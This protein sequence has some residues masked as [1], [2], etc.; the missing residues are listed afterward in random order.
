[1]KNRIVSMSLAVMLALSVGLIGCGGEGVPEVTEYTLTISSAEGGSVTG[2]GEG[3]FAYDE[4]EK[5]N[6][7]AKP[8]E[9]C[10]FVNWT[11]DI[12]EIADAED[13]T[14]TIAM[15]ADYVITAN[16]EQVN[17]EE[18]F[19]GGDGT[20]GDPYRLVNWC[21]LNN[22]RYFLSAHYMLMN[23]LDSATAGYEELASATANGGK[24]WETI[25]SVFVDPLFSLDIIDPVD[26]FTGSLDGQGHD[27]GD[28]FI[29]RAGEDGV[30]LFGCVVEAVIKNIGVVNAEVT[31]HICVGALLGAVFWGSTVNNS[32]SSGNVTG[33]AFVGGLI[34]QNSAT[35]SNS[36]FSGNVTGENQYVGGLVG[37][38]GG[39]VNSSYSTGTVTGESVVGGLSGGNWLSVSNC[40]S[41]GDVIGEA[42]VGGLVGLNH[43]GTVSHSYS[44]GTVT[45]EWN[46]G[47]LVGE[48]HDGTVS[49][50]H[51][52]YG[53]VLING[54]NMITVGA[55]SEEDFDKWV[56]NDR[57]LDINERLSQQDGYYLINSASDLKQLLAFGQ[58]GLLKFRLTNDLNLDDEPDFY[59]PYLAG[60]FDGD[61]HKIS[62]LN[63][64]LDLLSQVGLFGYLAS[65]GVVTGLGV[66]NVNITGNGYVGSLVG[67]NDGS[68][69]D[70]YSI[71]KVA[72]CCSVGGLVGWVGWR[73]GTV[74]NSYYNYDETLINNDRG[75]ITIGALFNEDFNQWLANGRFLDVNQRLTQEDGCYVISDVSDFKQL[76]AFG[77]NAS[78]RFRLK[79]DLNLDNELN[80]YVPYLAGEF[81]G[82]GH[83]ISNLKLDYDFVAQAGLFGYVA[84]GGKIS[85]VGV[86]NVDVAG[87]Q[88][89]G[90][91]VG[92]NA[93]T[94]NNSYSTGSVTGDGYVGGLVGWNYGAVSN[95][96]STC[97]ATGNGAAGGL[98][99]CNYDVMEP[100]MIINSYSKGSVTGN[101][102]AG[103]LV[104][105]GGSTASNSFWDTQTSGQS[106]SAGGTGK[107]TAEMKDTTTLSGAGWNVVAVAAPNI[108][109]PSYI[110]N[111]V[112]GQTYPFLSWQPIS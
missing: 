17:A 3:T 49:N 6:L 76:L 15:N 41:T 2:P 80:F 85:E 83:E 69:R 55:L 78:L 25:G 109:N 35:V 5:V 36:H 107:T 40:Y 10:Q 98:V 52:S 22:V 87:H 60:E 110:W 30:G 91:L 61:G 105:H 65:G 99:G 7:V 84:S 112:D 70:S 44:T 66:E 58:D 48:H 79:S 4:G 23:D 21:H 101:G 75:V 92:G 28:L 8:D 27:V 9:D 97:S 90:G 81:D 93:G 82:N 12:G 20:E 71:G 51:Y 33:G 42:I 95:S 68:V 64:S 29:D 56:R 32:Y 19:A 54:R 86:K 106:T 94:L 96:Y 46:V 16:F 43:V 1:M 37:G 18:L 74:I 111:I 47:G 59:I 45:G 100:G 14:T 102:A 50:S 13:A 77:Q 11:G 57:F 62:N 34:G 53:E 104:G 31:G 103:G 67:E 24:G 39:I 63:L 38:S 26:S 108:R 72:G 89:V 88:E 73:G